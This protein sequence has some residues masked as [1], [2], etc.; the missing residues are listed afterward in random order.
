M[1]IY[2][3]SDFKCHVSDDGNMTSV[4]TSFFDGKCNVFIEGYRYVPAAEEWMDEAG[5][6]F[7]GEMIA[8][9]RPYSELDA[10]QLAY[11]RGL[12]SEYSSAI[13]EIEAAISAPEVWGT[14][15]TIVEARKQNIITRINEIIETLTTSSTI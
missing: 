13:C 8:P 7:R 1:K 4:E 6:V 12:V 2:I 15:S 5:K 9:W 3:D 10:A 11:E 14:T